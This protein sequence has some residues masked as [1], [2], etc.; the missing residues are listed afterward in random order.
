MMLWFLQRHWSVVVILG[1]GLSVSAVSSRWMRAAEEPQHISLHRLHPLA[2]K[3]AEG[4]TQS[5]QTV[6]LFLSHSLPS[7]S[8]QPAPSA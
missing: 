7:L 1:S 8:W 5:G 4:N 2:A 3:T 6:F